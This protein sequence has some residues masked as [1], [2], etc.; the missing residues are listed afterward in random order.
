MHEEN[1]ENLKNETAR[2]INLAL[3]EIKELKGDSAIKEFDHE[4]LKEDYLNEISEILKGE[5]CK[6]EKSEMTVAVVGTMKAGKSTTI[7]AIVGSKVLPNRDTAMTA[8]PTLVR[9][10]PKQ[11]TPVMK[12]ENNKPLI[13]L[14][15]ELKEELGKAKEDKLSELNQEPG[16]EEL[17][18]FIQNDSKSL[19]AKYEGEDNIFWILRTLNDLV[20]LSKGFN[21]DFPFENYNKIH[22]LPVI[23]IEFTHLRE[24]ASKGTFTLLDTPGPNEAGQTALKAMLDNQLQ[25]ASAVL[26]IVDYSVQNSD[27]SSEV[28]E[29]IGNIAR[30]I[31]GRLFV[32]VNRFDERTLE[33]EDEKAIR[34]T[35]RLV[36][37]RMKKQKIEIT[38][39][40]V[41][42][43]SALWAYLTS[44]ARNYLKQN[45][46][47][48]EGK[49]VPSWA[50]NLQK[51]GIM[52]EDFKDRDRVDSRIN[53][54]WKQSNFDALLKEVI[55]ASQKNVRQAIIQSA[56]TKLDKHIEKLNTALETTNAGLTGETKEIKEEIKRLKKDIK[57][58]K[59]LKEE[60][61]KKLKTLNDSFGEAIKSS[62]E[63]TRK[64]TTETMKQFF[65]KELEEAT[66]RDEAEQREHGNILQK[67]KRKFQEFLDKDD[68]AAK[69]V[70][71][72]MDKSEIS[73]SNEEDRNLFL[74]KFQQIIQEMLTSSEK[75]TINEA[76][77]LLD[78]FEKDF[79]N[80]IIEGATK[81]IGGLDKRM[82][83]LG[84]DIRVPQP[85]RS[86]LKLE[87]TAEELVG[88]AESEETI[89]TLKKQD[90]WWASIKRGVDFFNAEWGYDD[91]ERTD[92]LLNLDEVKK[93]TQKAVG[94]LFTRLEKNI[95]QQLIKPTQ[96]S[97]Q[98]FFEK[99]TGKIEDIRSGF[100]VG[101]KKNLED[102]KTKEA[103]I[104]AIYKYLKVIK[105][106]KQDIK[107]LCTGAEKEGFNI[108][109]EEGA[110]N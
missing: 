110:K 94:E 18:E 41:F 12:L 75:H 19:E 2:L 9:H 71:E 28:R 24:L 16:M 86:D 63:N 4:H 38:E 99:L 81:V 15:A 13:K 101:L 72:Q 70:Y 87:V 21:I 37:N 78:T 35:K 52:K 47:L 58:I 89:G 60:S 97:S 23:E 67:A 79:G 74:E 32:L 107:Q 55:I 57:D 65:T 43:V 91:A 59:N 64:D 42:P 76:E 49:N 66:E 44:Q 34:E 31:K 80:T 56:V 25:K 100:A 105:E 104:N 109:I 102:K 82:V 90:G 8:I 95:G 84:L 17:I 36:A 85:K 77:A 93:E 68:D 51:I 3:E 45:N 50:K 62:T 1:I 26:A 54:S 22:E 7:N 98:D 40:Q 20:R 106:Q 6:L 61:L 46:K 69:K 88:N 53:S 11:V 108:D 27:A 103:I 29:S 48:P 96:K 92:Y 39:E 10:T 30:T 5:A 33:D 73:F 83:T 14:M